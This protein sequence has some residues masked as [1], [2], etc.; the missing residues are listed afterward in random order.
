MATVRTNLPRLVQLT[1]ARKLC[2]EADT[3]PGVLAALEQRFPGALEVV[4]A[5]EQF[6][7]HVMVVGRYRDD[8]APRLLTKPRDS[9]RG[10]VELKIVVVP[11]GG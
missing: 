3:L 7:A 11:D 8:E 1:G 10:L 6:G 5:G 9:R 4:V 2:V